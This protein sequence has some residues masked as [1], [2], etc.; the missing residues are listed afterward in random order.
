MA[1]LILPPLRA[2]QLPVLNSTAPND[3]TLSA[4]QIGKTVTGLCWILASGWIAGKSAVPWWWVAPTYHQASDAH[5]R[6]VAMTRG[7]GVLESCTNSVPLTATITSGAR[8]EFRSWERPDGLYGTTIRGGVVDEFGQLTWEAWA[9]IS[10]RRGETHGFLRMLGNVGPVGGPAEEIWNKAQAGASGFVGRRWTW[11]D[12]AAAAECVCGLNGDSMSIDTADLHSAG[13]ERAA[14][15]R[16]LQTERA[17]LP[18]TLFRTLHE[19]EFMDWSDLPVYSFDRAVHVRD[20]LALDTHLPLALCCD[21]NVDPM[22]WLVGQHLRGEV[23]FVDEIAI[24]GGA[25]TE[26]AVRE[27]LRRYPEWIS[28]VVIYGDASG[29]AR[30]TSASQT[31]YTIIRDALTKRFPSY[32]STVPGANPPVS[33]RVNAV[34]G[35]LRAANGE[36]HLVIHARCK[37]LIADLARVSWKPGT[38][39]I[40]K[41]DR[42]RTHASDAAGYF[43]VTEYPVRS[44][45]QP[46]PKPMQTEADFIRNDPVLGARW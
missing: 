17:T 36:T 21:F 40:D 19:A 35:R 12:R 18:G 29:S 27:F 41:S 44:Q 28:G 7:A 15:L 4:P 3:V 11:R 22:V 33:D 8:Y 25:T 24:P 34:N 14:Y 37:E 38:R 6:F 10:S 30:K 26:A 46:F 5:R 42:K 23:R 31:D 32:R 9:A 43:V 1:E 2:Y 16:F 20:D 39:D 45:S 13:C